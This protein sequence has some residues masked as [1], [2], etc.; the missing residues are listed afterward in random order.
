M[1]YITKK[2]YFSAAHRI[3]NPELSDEQNNKIYGKC[4]NYNGHGHN[5]TLEVTVKGEVNPT[6]GYVMDLKK[7]KSIIKDEIIEKLDH[8]HLNYDVE[9]L[10]GIIPT[11]ENLCIAFWGILQER[12]SEAEIYE[13]KLYESPNSWVCYRG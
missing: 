1:I 11:A 7:L 5:Y 12:I 9:F 13:I 10:Q 8:K 4:N 3:F 6:T 2:M